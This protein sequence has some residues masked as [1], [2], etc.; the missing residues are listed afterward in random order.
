LTGIPSLLELDYLIILV[1]ESFISSSYEISS[2]S[3]TVIGS[4]PEGKLR[5]FYIKVYIPDKLRCVDAECLKAGI[6]VPGL[7]IISIFLISQNYTNSS[8]NIFN[9]PTK[10][11]NLGEFMFNVVDSM[12]KNI[13]FSPIQRRYFE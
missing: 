1:I 5:I 2:L 6:A 11:R 13:L 8:L 9:Y 10:S 4:T 12:S 3:T 7:I